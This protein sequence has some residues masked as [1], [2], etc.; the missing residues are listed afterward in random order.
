MSAP[1][2]RDLARLGLEPGAMLGDVH[3]AWERIREMW[4]SPTLATYGL[5][6][7]GE[8]AEVLSRLTAAYERVL[9]AFG[10]TQTPD[11][12]ETW[13]KS[14]T[15][16]GLEPEPDRDNEPGAYLRY[17]RMSKGLTLETI[18]R[19]TRIRPV[20]LEALEAGDSGQLPEL[21][22]VR[23][24]V[25]AFSQAVGI[26]EPGEMARVYVEWLEGRKA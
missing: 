24:F 19:D 16:A 11:G 12:M 17:H 5:L 6:D 22:F 26:P 15:D 1:D 7:D 13:R 4:D 14:E 2:P 8:R 21:V 23:G 18:A 25:V 9:T 20:F 3:Q 10:I